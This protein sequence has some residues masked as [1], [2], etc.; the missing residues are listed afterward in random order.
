MPRIDC[1]TN[2]DNSCVNLASLE[3][4][5]IGLCS[6]SSL[7]QVGLDRV[8]G[9]SNSQNLCQVDINTGTG[10]MQNEKA[11][12]TNNIAQ[13]IE[14]ENLNVQLD[15][16][17]EVFPV[18]CSCSQTFKNSIRSRDRKLLRQKNRIFSLVLKNKFLKQKLKSRNS[19]NNN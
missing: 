6:S 5:N 16:Q 3:E 11:S 1:A 18:I 14:I 2:I 12:S 9:I 8:L 7:S 10:F 13:D 15:E 17:S 4:E 19:L